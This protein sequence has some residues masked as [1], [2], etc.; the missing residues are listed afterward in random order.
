[1]GTFGLL[2]PQDQVYYMTTDK[3]WTNSN[4]ELSSEGFEQLHKMT[5]GAIP[6]ASGSARQL[7]IINPTD[8]DQVV[9]LTFQQAA[10]TTVTATAVLLAS[11]YL[12]N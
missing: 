1:M 12:F 5:F 6:V 8:S 10:S 7:L 2:L 3:D 11:V 4:T 9:T